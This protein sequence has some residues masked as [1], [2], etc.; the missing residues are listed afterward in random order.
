MLQPINVLISFVNA[1]YFIR[2]AEI[3]KPSPKS[4]N[5]FKSNCSEIRVALHNM[6]FVQERKQKTI[7]ERCYGGPTLYNRQW[8]FRG[9][10]LACCFS[11]DCILKRGMNAVTGSIMQ[12][13]GFLLMV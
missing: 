1:T 2:N 8:E 4:S 3:C 13:I 9:S 10:C 12:F 5:N 11:T 7:N 6:S